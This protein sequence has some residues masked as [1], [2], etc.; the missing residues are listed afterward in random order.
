MGCGSLVRVGPRRLR[1][2]TVGRLAIAILGTRGVPARYSGFET[3][4]E[5]IGVRLAS[6]GHGVCVYRRSRFARHGEIPGIDSVTLPAIY[7]KHLETLSH[8][9]LS[10]LHCCSRRPDIALVCN[11]VNA[12]FLPLLTA[13]GIPTV[14]NVDGVE[15]QR[16]KWG[17]SGRAVH[18]LSEH[19]A[20]HMADIIVADSRTV[21]DYYRTRHGCESVFIPYGGELTPPESTAFLAR[22][23]LVPGDYDLCVCRFE[24]ENNPLTVVR[25]RSRL[26]TSTPLAMV[27]TAPYAS[28][29][30][31]AVRRAAPA[32]VRFL[33]PRFADEYR[34][35]LFDARLVV[36]AGEVGG[37]HPLLVE[38]MGAARPIIYNGTPENIETV[39]HAGLA[40]SAGSESALVEAWKR[41]DRSRQLRTG[42]GQRAGRRA[43]SRYR[44]DAVTLAYESLFSRLAGRHG[45][46]RGPV[47]G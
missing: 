27:G 44:W 36:Y 29:Y 18:R 33:G 1:R 13:A 38:A 14:L 47:V 5:Q 20:V 40:Y 10:V 26:S 32:S 11:T 46:G 12:A 8:T 34:Q 2:S 30:I 24:P 16:R 25:A 41:L 35:L 23:G 45:P 31:A 7:A 4:A 3:F 9:F 37:T 28:R 43:R 21:Q 17:A 19:L 6:R 39:G 42:L 22:Q 15:W